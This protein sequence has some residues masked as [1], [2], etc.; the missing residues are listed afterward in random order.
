TTPKDA[1]LPLRDVLHIDPESPLTRLRRRS[2]DQPV[3]RQREARRKRTDG[4]E[5]DI[6]D[7]ARSFATLDLHRVRLCSLTR[8]ANLDH[9]TLRYGANLVG[10]RQSTGAGYDHPGD[11]GGQDGEQQK[12]ADAHEN[13]TP[14][15]CGA[16][17][18]TV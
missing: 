17:L 13:E 9:R 2:A 4:L 7:A 15:Y 1:A 11:C 18:E 14:L 12:S 10:K 16:T 3:R 8:W 5:P 6:W